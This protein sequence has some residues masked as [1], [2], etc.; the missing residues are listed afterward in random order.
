MDCL[1]GL[2]MVVSVEVTAWQKLGGNEEDKAV[3][4]RLTAMHP[5]LLSTSQGKN[6]VIWSWLKR[7]G[8][9]FALFEDCLQLST[10]WVVS[11]NIDELENNLGLEGISGDCQLVQPPVQTKNSLRVRV[12]TWDLVQL[13]F[14]YIQG[15]NS[16]ACL[17]PLHQSKLLLWRKCF[18]LGTAWYFFHLLQCVT[19]ASCPHCAPIRSLIQSS[20]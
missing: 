17:A 18:P 9:K 15:C 13:C 3:A 5:L 8:R 7:L 4:R 14:K 19:I 2:E 6:S 11:T 20:L 12:D 10:E 1:L 16:T